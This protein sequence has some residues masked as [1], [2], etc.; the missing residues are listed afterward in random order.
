MSELIR[1]AVV[2]DHPLF[3]DGVSMILAG[4]ADIEVVGQGASAEEAIRLAHDL[5][6]DVMLLDIDMPGNGLEAARQIAETFPIIRIILLT[7]SEAEDNLLAAM[8][9][10]A[11]AYILKGVPGRELVRIVR[12]VLA[13][14]SYVPPALAASLLADLGKPASER[15]NPGEARDQLTQRELEILE[16]LAKGMSNKEIGDKLFLT[17]KTVKHYVT[18][19]LQKLQV[20]NRVEAA[21]LA[22]KSKWFEQK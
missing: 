7:V 6:P 11:R 12:L 20:H 21:L 15:H 3:R 9:V 1:I 13:G 2:D 5:L 8:K 19:I 4:E 22:Q 16:L 17:E 14:E 10:G 18:N